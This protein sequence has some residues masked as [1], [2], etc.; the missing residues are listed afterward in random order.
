MSTFSQHAFRI[1]WAATVVLA[2]AQVAFFLYLTQAQRS[3]SEQVDS[4]QNEVERR[5]ATIRRI[6]KARDEYTFD[7]KTIRDLMLACRAAEDIPD[8]PGNHIVSAYRQGGDSLCFYAPEGAHTLIVSMAWKPLDP[9]RAK[10]KQLAGQRVWKTPLL[11]SSGYWLSFGTRESQLR[12]SLSS[13]KATF[14]SQSG[15]PPILGK[16]GGSFFTSPKSVI[17]MPKPNA[18][19]S[20]M[21][22]TSRG[23]R[24]DEEYEVEIDV[25]VLSTSN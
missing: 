22:G 20:L 25:S 4:L 3:A 23:L 6:E 17:Q 12:W 21:S 5:Q 19:I 9:Q 1:G 14:V 13:N 2:L 18:S 16:P 24:D 7:W 15:K 11:P 10:G 8:L